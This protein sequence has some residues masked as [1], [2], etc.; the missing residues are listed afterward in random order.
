MGVD[1]EKIGNIPPNILK[2]CFSSLEQSRVTAEGAAAF[3]E[4]WTKKES[5]LKYLG[6]GI[7]SSSLR[8]A[9]YP[10]TVAFYLCR[11]EDYQVA[12][13]TDPLHLPKRIE[14]VSVL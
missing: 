8:D 6:E 5:Y 7:A 11:W 12:V 3:Y 10:D 14:Q 9:S 13:C 2:K 1:I 4:L